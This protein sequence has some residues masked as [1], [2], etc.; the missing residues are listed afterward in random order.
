KGLF[1]SDGFTTRINELEP[2][3]SDALLTFLFAHA[4]RPEFTVRWRWQAGDVAIWDNRA[5]QHY[6]IDDYGDQPRVVRRVTLGGD[7]PV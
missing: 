2:A 5:T 6:A 7:V 1:V 4:T 3:E